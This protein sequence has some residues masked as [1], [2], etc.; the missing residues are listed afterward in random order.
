MHPSLGIG[1]PDP[2]RILA[3]RGKLTYAE[4][5]R[6]GKIQKDIPLGD[7]A[8]LTKFLL[9]NGQ[10]PSVHYELGIVP[11][12]VD[13]SHP[14]IGIFAGRDDIKVLDPAMSPELFLDEMRK[15]RRVI[16][17][18]LHGLIFAEALGKPNCWIELSNDVVGDG[19]K[20]RDWYSLAGNPQTRPFR[21]SLTEPIETYFARCEPRGVEIDTNALTRALTPEVVESCADSSALHPHK[22]I[23]FKICRL[24]PVPIF[25]ISYNRADTLKRAI[26][27]YR[28]QSQ[29]IEI[30]VHDNGSDDPVTRA[31]LHELANDGVRVYLRE[32]I[33]SAEEL[34]YVDESITDYF[35][36]WAEP[37]NYVVT[38]CDIDLEIANVNA[39]S[40]YAELLDRF[41]KVECVGPML[42]ISDIPRKYPLFNHV[43]NR[44]IE[45]F[46]HRDP[47][48]TSISHGEVA[49]IEAPIDTSF[50][51]HR[52]GES[53]RRL[54]QG[55]RVYFPYEARHLDWYPEKA[56]ASNYRESSSANISHWNN[57]SYFE[58]KCGEALLFEEYTV[59][60][61]AGDGRLK[62]RLLT[63][64]N[65]N[66]E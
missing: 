23:P 5:S 6:A 66:P 55:L 48:F 24:K 65:D 8:F 13:R 17:S 1:D 35:E 45:Q 29:F 53:F 30:V 57:R 56:K 2:A 19:F 64:A 50:A 38:D 59:V 52:A 60:E 39:L 47:V 31:F 11:H 33:K 7:P 63:P 26:A 44:H 54:K 34:D 46:W 61:Q 58:S 9:P 14:L 62:K 10:A 20:F 32:P 41:R 15:C 49:Y 25:M 28:H 18:S 43:M 27:S 12:Y 40:V 51:V 16:S 3:V 42:R 37:S 21:L 22:L 4:L 36:N